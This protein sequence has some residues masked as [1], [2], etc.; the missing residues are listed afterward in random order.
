MMSTDGDTTPSPPEGPVVIATGR[1]DAVVFDLDGVITDT[2]VVHARAWHRLFDEFLSAR[3]SRAGEDHA[4]FT[5][6]DYLRY[7][8]GRPRYDGVRAFLVARGIDLDAASYRALGDR[9]DGYVRELLRHDGVDAF[10][11][12]VRLAQSLAAAGIGCG[13]ISASRHCAEVLDA[14]GVAALFGVR[15]DGVEADKLDLPGKPDPAVFL[16]AAHRLGVQPRRT[17]VVEDALAG[18]AAGR[19][20][21]FG[22]VIGVDRRATGGHAAALRASGADVV[23]TDLSAVTVRDGRTVPL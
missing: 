15:V 18:V 9:K 2:A 23:V 7:V 1:Y 22:L 8:D 5:Q 4:P 11:D 14:A 3:P 21:G 6:A 13:V 12:T 10:P 20:G 16:L 19:A 17:V